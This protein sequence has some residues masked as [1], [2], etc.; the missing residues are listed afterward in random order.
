MS[1]LDNTLYEKLKNV[2]VPYHILNYSD[3]RFTPEE[4]KYIEKQLRS[5]FAF[6]GCTIPNSII[7]DNVEIPLNDF[8]WRL[9]TK[10]RLSQEELSVAKQLMIL[11]HQKIEHNK[12]LIHEY[13]LTD[14][15]AEKLYFEAC[16]MLK[17]LVTLRELD[18]NRNQ[19]MM[20]S[21][22]DE[23][24]KDAKRLLDLINK[25]K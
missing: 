17:A 10:E 4:R 11:L 16:G 7:E 23:K 21:I 20:D 3:D 13:N 8:I 1:E 2:K 25:I 6:V 18:H 15:E 12:R 22:K 9:L 19:T 14:E 5:M 24:I